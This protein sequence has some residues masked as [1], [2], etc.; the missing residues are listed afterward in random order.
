MGKIR[1]KDLKYRQMFH[2]DE[3]YNWRSDK[4][5]DIKKTLKK[6][7]PKRKNK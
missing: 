5:G 2:P 7:P 4:A 3:S 6:R 1:L